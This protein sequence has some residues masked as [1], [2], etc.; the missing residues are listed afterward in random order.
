VSYLRIRREIKPTAAPTRRI[1]TVIASR[2]VSIMVVEKVPIS[3]TRKAEIGVAIFVI[4][5]LIALVS[6]GIS[7]SPL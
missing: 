5:V 4:K 6:S 7:H 2:G 1:P 3:V